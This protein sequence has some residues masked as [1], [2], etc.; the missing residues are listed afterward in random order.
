MYA[1]NLKV[2][3]DGHKE[4]ITPTQKKYFKF[5]LD[6][7]LKNKID[8]VKVNRINYYFD[9]SKMQVRIATDNEI[10]YT[11]NIRKIN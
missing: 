7:A 5:A 1:L 11:Y 9:F 6:F 4:Y 2:C 3:D 10:G 8:N